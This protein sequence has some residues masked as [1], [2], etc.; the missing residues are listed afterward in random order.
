[1]AKK[2]TKKAKGGRIYTWNNGGRQ[3]AIHDSGILVAEAAPPS[4]LDIPQSFINADGIV[5]LTRECDIESVM[6]EDVGTH[7]G[8]DK[9]LGTLRGIQEEA[10]KAPPAG[11]TII[12][13]EVPTGTLGAPK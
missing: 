5:V 9:A 7:K 4:L 3:Q 1:M 10:R 13:G 11:P 12:T 2:T 6:L 8:L